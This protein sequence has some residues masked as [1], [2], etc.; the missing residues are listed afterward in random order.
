MRTFSSL[1]LSALLAST[2]P[3]VLLAAEQQPFVHR[4]VANDAK[5]Y[6]DYVKEN[7][8]A[9]AKKAPDLRLAAEKLMSTDPRG[10]SRLYAEAASGDSKT[11]QNWLGL[12]QA[13]LA[14]KPDP[15]KGSEQYD[16]PVNASGAAYRAYEL[17]T[18][19]A[20]KARALAV[21]G[22]AMERRSYWR[23]AIDAMKSSLALADNASVREAYEKLRENHGFRMTDYRTEQDAAVPR[24]CVQFSETLS[25]G[26]VDFAKFVS[27]DGKDPQTVTVEGS[28]LCIEGVQH[29]QR[30][31]VQLRAGLPSD[32]NEN[33]EKGVTLA[34]YVPDRKPAVHFTGK[35]YV[36]PSRGQQGIPLVSINT[37]KLE[38]EVYRI[39]DRN[40][41]SALTSGDFDRQLQGYELEQIKNNSG[42]QVY[43]GELEVQSKLNDEVTTAFPVSEAVGQL[44]PGVYVL[45]AK[46]SGLSDTDGYRA[47]ATQWFIVSDLGLTSFTGADGVHAFVRSLATAEPIADANVRLVA[48]NNEVL[49]TVKSDKNGYVR[50]DAGQAKGVGG[51]QPQ[52]LVAE[53]G[54]GEYAF[55]DLQANAFDLS[56][57]GSTAVT[58]PGQSMLTSIRNAVFI[59]PVKR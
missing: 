31:E 18:D 9:V 29:G 59:A 35:S 12:A 36:L 1:L 43:A 33:L 44:Q 7:W 32:V 27:V 21:L 20:L 10:A 52:I 49:A 40:L 47:V 2:S 51:L 53:K 5:R 22:E 11:A 50:F 38:V 58:R 34:V 56:D 8:R 19:K 28:Q 3:G 23:P 14:I 45:S 41:A 37:E 39:G 25:R 17:A 16:L 24:L 4:G 54:A 48:R 6:E 30:Y 55:L 42:S 46:P 26:Q 15:D 57:R 13:L